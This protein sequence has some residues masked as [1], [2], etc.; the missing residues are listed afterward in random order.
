MSKVKLSNVKCRKEKMS[1]VQNVDRQIVEKK[2]STRR[3][4]KT[5]MSTSKNIEHYLKDTE[6]S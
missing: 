2:M 3:L 5:K 6:L 4:S 1:I